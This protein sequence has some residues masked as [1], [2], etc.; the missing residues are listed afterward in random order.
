[1][2]ATTEESIAEGFSTF[3]TSHAVSMYCTPNSHAVIMVRYF[4]TCREL[5]LQVTLN[6]ISFISSNVT[7]EISECLVRR[8]L[9][10]TSNSN[11][12]QPV[13][14]CTFISLLQVACGSPCTG[15]NS[16]MIYSVG[17]VATQ[18]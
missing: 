18:V 11:Y 3:W 4:I 13:A 16:R 12:W 15:C 1:M 7:M 14:D 2:Y 6:G 8:L 10:Q 5:L 9:V 17:I